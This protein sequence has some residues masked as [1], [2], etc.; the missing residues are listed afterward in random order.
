MKLVFLGDSLTVGAYGGNW[1][2]LVAAQLPQHDIINAGVGGDTI[3]NLRERTDS[4]LAVHQPDAVFV[5]VGGNDAVSY[6]M[7]DTRLYYKSSKKILPDGIVTPNRFRTQYR[8]L[9]T[10]LLTERVQPLVGLATTEYNAE[11]VAARRHYNQIARATAN[12]L[13]VPVCDLETAFMPI[14]P[15]DREPVSLAFIQQIGRNMASGWNDFESERAR[16]GYQ[17]TFDGMHL[18]PQTAQ[19]MADRVVVFLAEQGF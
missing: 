3:V 10:L 2:T 4:L 7:P 16:W 5:M 13:D 17:H 14:H 1:V 9:L 12:A 19:D 18:L 8:D 15:I 6:I 11:L